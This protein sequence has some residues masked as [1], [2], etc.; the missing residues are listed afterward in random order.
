M[1]RSSLSKKISYTGEVCPYCD[2]DRPSQQVR[3]GV[4]HFADKFLGG[5]IGGFIGG[6]ASILAGKARTIAPPELRVSKI[7]AQNAQLPKPYTPGR[8]TEYSKCRL[9][10]LEKLRAAGLVSELEY[11]DKRK[12]ILNS[13]LFPEG[14]YP[15]RQPGEIEQLIR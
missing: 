8:S 1:E 15:H 3:A 6:I 10:A 13:S 9:M 11:T 5:L 14:S 2:R 4:L 7:A 12:A